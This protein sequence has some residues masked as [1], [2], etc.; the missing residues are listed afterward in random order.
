MKFFVYTLKNDGA[1][2]AHRNTV[3]AQPMREILS[4]MVIR[5]GKIYLSLPRVNPMEAMQG[6]M[7]EVDR[8]EISESLLWV[9]CMSSRTPEAFNGWVDLS[10]H[11]RV[12]IDRGINQQLAE[13]SRKEHNKKMKDY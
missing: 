5:A 13:V 11:T 9:Q 7:S 3:N 8:W 2:H 6:G 10:S 1:I 4:M 12:D